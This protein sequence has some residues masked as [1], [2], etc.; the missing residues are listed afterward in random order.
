MS[1]M[2]H[3]TDTLPLGVSCVVHLVCVLYMCTLHSCCFVFSCLCLST[4]P[5]S[6]ATTL[7]FPRYPLLLSILP[8]LGC[9]P[10]EL[11][12]SARRSR[13]PGECHRT[14][15]PGTAGQ[16]CVCVCVV[17]VCVCVRVRVRVHVHV[18]VHAC[19]SV[20]ACSNASQPHV[21]LSRLLPNSPPLTAQWQSSCTWGWVRREGWG[22][23]ESGGD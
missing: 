7:L 20:C 8:C 15:A 12:L 5:L 18:H 9:L 23:E 4:T 13:L 22:G 14:S 11:G 21:T 16:L 10:A 3:S 1:M 6:P 17:C 19:V 2:K